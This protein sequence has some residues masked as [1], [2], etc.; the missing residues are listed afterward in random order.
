MDFYS[1]LFGYLVGW[2]VASLFWIWYWNGEGVGEK[3]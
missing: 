3:T 1:W 2:A